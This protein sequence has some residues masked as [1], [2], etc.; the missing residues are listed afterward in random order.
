[1]VELIQGILAD[2]DAAAESAQAVHVS[3][4]VCHYTSG[5]VLLRQAFSNLRS[6]RQTLCD[7]QAASKQETAVAV[8]E[9]MVGLASLTHDNPAHVP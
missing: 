8:A 2:H 1:M 6:D 4:M 5:L 9:S 3:E 7:A